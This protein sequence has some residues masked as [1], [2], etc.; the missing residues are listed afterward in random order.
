MAPLEDVAAHYSKAL[1]LEC[2]QLPC[3]AELWE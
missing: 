2:S 3:L 1:G